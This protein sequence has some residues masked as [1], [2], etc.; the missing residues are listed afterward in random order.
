MVLQSVKVGCA[1]V[2]EE[3]QIFAWQGADPPRST[4]PV[5]RGSSDVSAGLTVEQLRTPEPRQLEAAANARGARAGVPQ[6]QTVPPLIYPLSY[7]HQH[8]IL[9]IYTAQRGT[10]PPPLHPFPCRCARTLSLAWTRLDTNATITCD[11]E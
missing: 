4:A 7:R 5:S 3:A 1:G 9:A 8:L 2:G 10:F 6:P 11:D